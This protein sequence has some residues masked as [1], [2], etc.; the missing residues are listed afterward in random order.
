MRRF[1]IPLIALLLLV[2][3]GI[4][5]QTAY[6]EGEPCNTSNA[7]PTGTAC[8]STT[9]EFGSCE[10]TGETTSPANDCL[11]SQKDASGDCLPGTA[12]AAIPNIPITPPIVAPQDYSYGGIMTFIMSI[13]A[14]LLGVSA[15]LL[16]YAVYYTVVTM[17][18]YVKNITAIGVAWRI[19]RDIGNIILIFGFLIIGISTII[20][21][22]I[23]GWGSK[24]IPKLILAA[25]FLNFSL[26]FAQAV[27]DTGNLF[28]TQFYTQ[29]NGGVITKPTNL[30]FTQFTQAGSSQGISSKVM[31]QLGLQRLY[32][33]AK[34]NPKLLSENSPAFVAIL[35]IILFIVMAFVFFSLAFILI[36]RFVILIFLIITA[37]IGFAGMAVPKLEKIADEWWSQLFEQ[38]ATAPILLLLL[39][40]ALAVIT[41]V[42]FLTGFG[43]TNG[44]GDW[45][46]IIGNYANPTGFAGILIS[47]LVAMGLLLAVI[48]FAK[49][50]GAAGAAGAMSLGKKIGMGSIKLAGSG[51]LG[52]GRFAVRNTAGRAAHSL[53]QTVRTSGIGATVGGRLLATTLDKG[54]KGFKETKEKSV[55]SHEEYIKS[56]HGAIEEK[57][58]PAM[59]K[60]QQ[61]NEAALTSATR[62]AEQA[63][64]EKTRATASAQPVV[65]EVKRLEKIV[66][67]SAAN[68]A[69]GGTPDYEAIAA[70]KRAK[71]N[72]LIVKMEAAE[73]KSK[74]AAELLQVAE[75][76]GSFA[77]KAF[78]AEKKGASQQYAANISPNLLA[79]AIYGPGGNLAAMKIMKE[80]MKKMTATNE[81]FE[82]LKKALK[83]ETKTAGESVKTSKDLNQTKENLAEKTKE[84]TEQPHA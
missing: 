73:K 76:G 6:A 72:P 70:L 57:H 56:V 43:A 53:S 15:L 83:E 79:S 32:G 30:S 80:S 40:V 44:P 5:A 67:D 59:A 24:A 50:L 48:I 45:T 58:M 8:S 49:K 65:D 51:A 36:A 74:T 46:A 23:Y 11:E 28:A 25:I 16:D 64:E 54:G 62:V 41:D 81:A 14:W 35:G 31:S 13:F 60:E 12:L 78:E 4:F 17:G 75:K 68:E 20:K 27:I 39:Y 42:N 66:A 2:S 55:K 84:E 47:F 18:D 1:S 71:A 37:P 9:A 69:K 29:I 77:K 21:Y 63:N 33:D 34:N 19:L 10:S 22:D 52:A 3:G 38:T 82:A 61:S 7:C 26:F